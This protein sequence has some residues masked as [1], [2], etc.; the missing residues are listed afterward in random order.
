MSLKYSFL[1]SEL[2]NTIYKDN[3]VKVIKR[4]YQF[5]FSPIKTQKY[6][7]ILGNNKTYDIDQPIKLPEQ[8]VQENNLLIINKESKKPILELGNK[9]SKSID[10]KLTEQ[11][12]DS[13]ENIFINQ[14]NKTNSIIKDA[15][16]QDIHYIKITNI[17]E[18]IPKTL[19]ITFHNSKNIIIPNSKL[20]NKN[21]IDITKK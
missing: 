12:L 9:R 4:N 11:Q 15:Y 3:I 7:I 10:I 17:V 1:G 21:L 13:L 8:D 16:S 6:K 19:K 18:K 14:K 2:D 5:I 20:E